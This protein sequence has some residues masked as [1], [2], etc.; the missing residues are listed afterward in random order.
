MAFASFPSQPVEPSAVCQNA[1]GMPCHPHLH[2]FRSSREAQ[3]D[4]ISFD[5]LY[6]GNRRNL[7]EVLNAERW[8]HNR[9]IQGMRDEREALE[10]K[11]RELTAYADSLSS[12]WNRCH[13]ELARCDAERLSL[14]EQVME[15][16]TELEQTRATDTRQV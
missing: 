12:S 8:N 2:S 16:T 14:F 5:H 13:N 15:L 11:I 6:A 9:E 7:I 1:R 10:L 3:L 4:N